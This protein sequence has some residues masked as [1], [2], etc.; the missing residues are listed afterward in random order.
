MTYAWFVL[1]YLTAGVI[2]LLA[3]ILALKPQPKDAL[4]GLIALF[5]PM[6]ILIDVV[7]ALSSHLGALVRQLATRFHK[8]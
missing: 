1:I 3:Y 2:F 7:L 4:I 8:G 5:W 6:V